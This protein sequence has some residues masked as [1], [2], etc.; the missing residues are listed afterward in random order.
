MPLACKKGYYGTNCS[1]ECSPKCQPNTCKN[2]DGGCTCISGWSG[3]N[4][5]S[6]IVFANDFLYYY[7][8]SRLDLMSACKTKSYS[9]HLKQY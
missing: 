6:G 2:T 4:C 9:P 8:V 3:N 1:L 5:T 7:K